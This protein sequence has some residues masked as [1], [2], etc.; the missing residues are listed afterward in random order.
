MSKKRYYYF[1]LSS[2][3]FKRLVIKKMKMMPGGG[4]LL[5][6]YIALIAY[7]TEEEGVLIYQ[8]VETTLAKELSMALD[9][10]EKITQSLLIF[11]EGHN[12]LEKLD[13]TRFLLVDSVKMIGTETD[14]AERMRRLRKERETQQLPSDNKSKSTPM[15]AA[16]RTRKCRENKK[17]LQPPV[18]P[19][20]TDVSL[21]SNECNEESVTCNKS[22]TLQCNES[23]TDE[24]LHNSSQTTILLDDVTER[25]MFEQNSVTFEHC[26]TDID[27]ELEKERGEY[28]RVHERMYEMAPEIPTAMEDKASLHSV[29]SVSQN[30]YMIENFIAFRLSG[31]GI[32][33][34][35]AFEESIRKNLSIDNSSER[36]RF[37]EWCTLSQ[38]KWSAEMEEIYSL[39]LNFGHKDRTQCKMLADDFSHMYGY[40]ISSTL[41]EVIFYEVCKPDEREAI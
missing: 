16:E 30:V 1:K 12:L 3:F 6:T 8:G 23:V 14:A 21:Q 34:P 39:F 27:I 32:N 37:E 33:I 22:A 10:E 9:C 2:D 36:K 4:D 17:L 19:S 29:T 25:T 41:F 5:A 7:S 28:V 18:E 20:V 40:E 31:G 24:A 13:N 26:S 15:S 11:L 38:K 35:Y